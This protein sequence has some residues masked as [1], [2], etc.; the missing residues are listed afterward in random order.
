VRQRIAVPV[1]I[2]RQESSWGDGGT[3]GFAAASH[4]AFVIKHTPYSIF[5]EHPQRKITRCAQL[6]AGLCAFRR[7]FLEPAAARTE[8]LPMSYPNPQG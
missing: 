7:R 3:R 4:K 6:Q 1:G 5:K 8:L 2:I